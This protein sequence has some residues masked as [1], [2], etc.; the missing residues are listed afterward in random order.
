MNFESLANST[1]GSYHRWDQDIWLRGHDETALA[2]NVDPR[3]RISAYAVLQFG[4]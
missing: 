4:K 1:M 2:R 3:W